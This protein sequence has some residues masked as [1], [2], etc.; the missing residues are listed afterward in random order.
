MARHLISIH[1]LTIAEVAGLFRLAASVK[2]EPEKYENHMHRK[3]LGMIF[4]KSSTRT[5]VSFEVGMAQMGGHALFL[6]SRD[7]QLGRGE[8]ISDTAQVLSR[9]VDGIM[10][11][12]FAHQTVTDLAKYGSVPVINGL[13]VTS[14]PARG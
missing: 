8:P 2:S 13:T 3:T 9:Y 6:S 1:D 5:R 12:T 4:E 7:I 10:A 14:I 11:R